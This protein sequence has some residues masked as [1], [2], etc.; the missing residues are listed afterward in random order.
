MNVFLKKGLIFS[1][2]ALPM[3]ICYKTHIEDKIQ[4]SQNNKT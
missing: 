1:G 4:L 3:D 2:S